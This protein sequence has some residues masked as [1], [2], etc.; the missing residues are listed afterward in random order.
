M[1]FSAFSALI[2]SSPNPRPKPPIPCERSNPMEN[3]ISS[4][5]VSTIPVNT[6]QVNRLRELYKIFFVV[7]CIS[8]L[9]CGLMLYDTSA[10]LPYD[11]EVSVIEDLIFILAITISVISRV[12]F[13]KLSVSIHRDNVALFVLL[14]LVPI[15]YWF[16]FFDVISESKR[17]I[18][19]GCVDRTH[20]RVRIYSYKKF[21]AW[22]L[23]AA[24]IV[25]VVITT[26]FFIP[27][28]ASYRDG[29]TKERTQSG[30]YQLWITQTNV[31]DEATSTQV[32]GKQN[33]DG[34]WSYSGTNP[35]ISLD[36]TI[37]YAQWLMITF[38]ESMLLLLP[39]IILFRDNALRSPNV[40]KSI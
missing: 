16:L 28:Y 4:I 9:L 22:L 1:K 15:A 39:S 11:L 8:G 29:N 14:S 31:K 25:S 30:Y 35:T 34:S 13:Y 32:T 19:T 40:G 3:N 12:Y 23:L 20:R 5:P 33:S 2:T 7:E 6:A 17:A 38:V 36:L 21:F 18:Q 26:V 27:K 10:F 24:Y 37:D